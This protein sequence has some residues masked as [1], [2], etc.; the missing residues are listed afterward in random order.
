MLTNF[1]LVRCSPVITSS[2]GTTCPLTVG[3]SAQLIYVI[4]TAGFNL[5]GIVA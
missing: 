2:L 4:T 5:I 3:V 1:K